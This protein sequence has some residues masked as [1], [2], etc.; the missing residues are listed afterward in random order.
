M[1]EYIITAD[2]Q[3]FEAAVIQ[4]SAQLPV[5]VDFW[6]PWC[7]PCRTLTPVLESLA[8]EG[9]GAWLLVKVNTDENPGLSHRFGIRGIPNVKAFRN[10]KVVDEFVGALPRPQVKAFIEKLVPA[11]PDRRLAD[12]QRMAASGNT[13]GARRAMESLVAEQ[14]R[15]EEARLALAQLLLD[16]GDGK[17]ALKTLSG[18][19]EHG[20]KGSAVR[21]LKAL[22]RFAEPVA[23]EALH[24]ADSLA[25]GYAQA[26]R[27]AQKGDWEAAADA[28]LALLAIDRDYAN[29]GAKQDLLAIFEILG[30]Q[31]PGTAILRN[32]LALLLFA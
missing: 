14:P 31:D 25:S 1:T 26:R 20:P 4:R 12:A 27:I 29:G 19:P 21:R 6:A 10:G 23:D 15:S 30:D 3:T 28:L 11:A 18:I 7:G 32:R 16:T 9:K 24:S 17:A 13:E 8:S 22:A 5:L 2:E